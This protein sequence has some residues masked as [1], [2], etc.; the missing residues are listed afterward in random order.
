MSRCSEDF[1]GNLTKYVFLRQLSPIITFEN[2]VLKETNVAFSQLV[3][4]VDK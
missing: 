1:C 2:L 3:R 4:I